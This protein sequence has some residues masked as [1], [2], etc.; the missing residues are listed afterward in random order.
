MDLYMWQN[1]RKINYVQVDRK[2]NSQVLRMLEEG[3]DRLY[4][5]KP[6]IRKGMEPKTNQEQ[7]DRMSLANTNNTQ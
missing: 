2:N 7:Q 4:K 1:H 6:I 3:R 5:Y